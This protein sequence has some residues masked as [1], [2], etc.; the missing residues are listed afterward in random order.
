MYQL[1]IVDDEKSVVDSLALTIPWADFGIEQV[2]QAYSAAEALEIAGH[3]AID[4]MITDIRMPEMDGLELIEHI[5]QISKKMK[6]IIL[7]G[8]DDFQYAQKALQSNTFNY[9]L[10]PVIIEELIE[11]VQKAMEVLESEWEEISSFQRIQYTLKSNLPL[12]RDQ[13]LNDLLNNKPMFPHIFQERL[14]MLGLSFQTGD[15]FVMM[16]VR[17]E[18]DFSGYDLQSLSLLEYAVTNI[19]EEVFS[20]IFELWHATCDQGYLI[21]LIKSTK[22]DSEKLIHSLA[23]KV[24][25]HVETFLKGSISVF[26]GSPSQFPRDIASSYQNAVLSIY[27]NVGKNKSYFLTSHDEIHHIHDDPLLNVDEPP[28]LNH[29]LHASSWDEALAKIG[30]ILYITETEKELSN[31]QLFSIFLYL[32]S[33]FSLVLQKERGNLQEKLGEDFDLFLRKTGFLSKQRLYQWAEKLI[34]SMKENSTKILEDSHQQITGKV[35]AY[36]Q[37]HLAEGIS[38]NIIAEHVNLHPVY[39]SKVYKTVTGETIGDYLFSI[40]MERASYFLEQTDLKIADIS[41]KLGFLAPPHFIKIFKKHYG[42][43]PQEYRNRG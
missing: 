16:L 38:L 21:F 4:I 9:L 26:V 30:R 7:S 18:E 33:A 3:Q 41:S 28:H 17:L 2:H 39:L 10:K 31:D 42:Y 15:S 37:E 8:H 5:N 14:Q 29:L 27:R 19:A 24:Q 1:L 40:R 23:I 34:G 35:Q 36:I 25:N 32:S 43:T 6:C 11:S 12:L 22:P 13:L 20:D